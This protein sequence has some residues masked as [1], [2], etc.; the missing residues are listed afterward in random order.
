MIYDR[1]ET[2]SSASLARPWSER[3][4]LLS[5]RPRVLVADDYPDIVKSVSRLL[6][7]DCEVLGSVTD[8]TALLETVQR[9]QPDVIVLDVHLPNV[10]TLEACREMTRVNPA[11]KVVMFTAVDEPSVHQ[12]FVEAGASAVVSKLAASD[13]PGI[14]K[15]LCDGRTDADGPDSTGPT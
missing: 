5:T 13:L 1:A 4:L 7:L 9:L 10:H 3:S 6:A 2:P 15:R 14:I 8:G 11:M 12:A